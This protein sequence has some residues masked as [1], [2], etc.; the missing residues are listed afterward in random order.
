MEK[1]WKN[2]SYKGMK[3]GLVLCDEKKVDPGRN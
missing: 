1:W 2:K 3:K